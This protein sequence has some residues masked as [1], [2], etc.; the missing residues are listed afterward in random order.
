M[1]IIHEA[2]KKA[3]R[4]RA[5]RPRGLL[6][7]GPVR[8]ARRRWHWRAATGMLIGLTTVGAVSTGLWLHSHREDLPVRIVRPM[9]QNLPAV[10]L[11]DEEQTAPQML[12]THLPP[13]QKPL[14]GAPSSLA[15][16]VPS[17]AAPLT[18]ALEAQVAAQTTFERARE[19]EFKG[20]WE[21]AKGYYRQALTLN[22]S[23]VEA[24]NNLGTL[25]VRQR[26]LT[27]AIEEFQAA[28]RLDPHYAMVRN[29]LG[30][31]YFLSGQETLAIQE[32]LAA[33]HIDG[34][35]VSPL[36]NLASLYARRGDVGQAVAFLTR[37]L[38]IEPAVLSWLQEDPDFN[39]IKAAP[40]VQRLYTQGH[41]KR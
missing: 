41:A 22:P 11:G 14:A 32:F 31:A 18:L 30:S 35:Y 27:A 34:A 12:V 16:D 23:L 1:S 13:I 3:E 37:A 21:E 39:S 26:Q 10:V 5:P 36:Y 28:I 40:D 17:P 2:L 15:E 25:Y 20:Q 6:H 8:T 33:L 7:Y 19:S 4:E 38:V 9:R 24:R 29:N